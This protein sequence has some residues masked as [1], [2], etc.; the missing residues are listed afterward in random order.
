MSDG[1]GGFFRILSGLYFPFTEDPSL[2]NLASCE[3]D[4]Q[5]TIGAE[6]KR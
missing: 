5:H 6:W 2:L 1:L 4:C 3:L